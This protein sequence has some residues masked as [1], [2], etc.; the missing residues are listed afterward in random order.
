MS[1]DPDRRRLVGALAA[2]AVGAALGPSARAAEARPGDSAPSGSGGRRSLVVRARREGI[3]S[4]DGT[5]NS[6]K[7]D[8]ALGGAVARSAS[9]A[10]AAAAFAQL[11][12]PDDVVGIKLNTLAGKGLSPRPELVSRLVRWLEDAGV[13]GRRILVWDRSDREMTRAGFALSRDPGRV[14]Y[15]GVNDAW[16]W[17]PREW[18]PGASCFARILTEE[19]TALINVGVLKDHD[20]AGVSAGMKNWYGAIH[21]PNKHHDNGCH[22]FVAHLAAFPLIRD[23]LKLTVIDGLTAQCHGGPARS[24]K[25]SWPWGGVLVSRDPVALDAVAWRLIEERRKEVGL[26][27]LAQEGREPKWI[28]TAAGLGLGTAEPAGI[29]LEDA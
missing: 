19:V 16:E 10:S 12:R 1:F 21:N 22:P 9:T 17:K 26:P 4:P 2:G 11:F 20:L 8:D 27:T 24:A 14:R 7:L 13:A 28:A 6:A 23:R 29:R 15:L 3:V 18:G 5:P 25:W